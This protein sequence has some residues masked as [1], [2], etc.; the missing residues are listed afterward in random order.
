MLRA[1]CTQGTYNSASR[2]AAMGVAAYLRLDLKNQ[3]VFLVS[4]GS[5]SA[6]SLRSAIGETVTLLHPPST[7]SRCFNTD[8][9]GTCQYNDC[10]AD[11]GYLRSM[12]ARRLTRS[13]D[14][15]GEKTGR[16][17]TKPV[18]AAG[19]ETVILLT[20]IA[21]RIETI[22]KGR[23]RCS[24][25]TELVNGYNEASLLERCDLVRGEPPGRGGDRQRRHGRPRGWHHALAGYGRLA[26]AAGAGGGVSTRAGRSEVVQLQPQSPLEPPL[27]RV[28]HRASS[29]PT[30]AALEWRA[31]WRGTVSRCS[32]LPVP[33]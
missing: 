3:K 24:R 27:L 21:I 10:L 7:F 8:G 33:A 12:S 18:A 25:M 11:D 9:E 14:A 2:R 5:G 15:D 29:V 19:G 1:V 6:A 16:P 31:R 23:G 4:S 28:A 26:A 20:P 22:T 17:C 32:G 13:G 30:A